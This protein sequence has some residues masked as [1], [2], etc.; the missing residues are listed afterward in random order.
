MNTLVFF[1]SMPGVGGGVELVKV[2]GERIEHGLVLH[3][4]ICGEPGDYRHSWYGLTTISD[5]E[6]GCLIDTGPSR[7]IVL[8]RLANRIANLG[9]VEV[10]LARL[11]VSRAEWRATHGPLGAR[12]A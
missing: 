1:A 9:G 4:A 12:H 6:T 11:A 2:E 8:G 3:P 5:P 7:E 10:F